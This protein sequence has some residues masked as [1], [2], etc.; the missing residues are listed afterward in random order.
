MGHFTHPAG[1]S[2]PDLRNIPR[3]TFLSPETLGNILLMDLNFF[4]AL[5]KWLISCSPQV[6]ATT[7]VPHIME[8]TGLAGFGMT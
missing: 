1:R 6:P 5:L 8:T 2:P 4:L 7:V 3:L